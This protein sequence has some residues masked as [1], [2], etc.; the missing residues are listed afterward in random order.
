MIIGSIAIVIPSDSF[1]PRPGWPKFGDVWILVVVPADAVPDQAADDGEP[2]RFDDRL[3]RGRDVPDPVAGLR[4]G[5]PCGERVLADVEQPLCLGVDRSDAEG[6]AASA[7][8][9]SRT[10]PTSTVIRSPSATRYGP[11]MPWTTIEFG[12]MQISAGY[13]P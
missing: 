12:E 9:P 1:G 8:A 5:D 3:D 10:A 7:M 6:V 2:G 13:V 4:L 11:G